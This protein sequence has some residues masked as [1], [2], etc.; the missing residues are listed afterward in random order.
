MFHRIRPELLADVFRPV[1]SHLKLAPERLRTFIDAQLLI[2]AQTTSEYTNA[3]YGASALDLPR[4]GVRVFEGGTGSI[5]ARLVQAIRD[6]GGKVL[7]RHEVNKV[8]IKPDK[9][10]KVFTRQGSVHR[11]EK[12]VFNLPVWNI[13]N[14]MGN[15]A[16]PRLRRISNRPVSGWG[17]FM[18]YIGIDGSAVS[19]DLPLH[20][21]ILTERGLSEGASIF[22]SISPAWDPTRGPNGGHAITISTHTALTGWW[23]LFSQ[24]QNLFESR[25]TQYLES[26][27]QAASKV[28]PNIGEAAQVIFPGTPVTFERFTGRMKG[29][30]GGF[31]QTNFLQAWGPRL[32]PAIWMVGDSIFPGQSIAA[33]ALG[34][35]TAAKQIQRE[36]EKEFSHTHPRDIQAAQPTSRA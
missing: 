35:L 27:I 1:A 11:A 23:S 15:H 34:G 26:V 30:V 17:A 3:L 36:L 12:L 28:I 6:N 8:T 31:P 16:P 24:N 25:K 32:G 29:W 9:S 14:I 33:T 5:A 7:F 10:Y 2:S 19:K 20:H 13:L 21:Q 22:L 4:R 18:T